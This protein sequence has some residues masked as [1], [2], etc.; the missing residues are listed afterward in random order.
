V[1]NGIETSFEV[2][3]TV[4]V[5]KGRRI[6]WP[7]GEFPEE[8]FT[9]GNARPLDQALQHATTEM[10]NWLTADFG[11]DFIDASHV[12]GQCV[13]FGM[14]S[15][16]VDGGAVARIARQNT[17]R[18]GASRLPVGDVLLPLANLTKD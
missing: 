8:I 17:S 11:L 5:L 7:R 6:G 13:R 14:V 18:A 4:R 3:F 9:V 10:R 2:E 1:G 16:G 15:A 12:L